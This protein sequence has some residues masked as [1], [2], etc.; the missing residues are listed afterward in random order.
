MQIPPVVLE[1]S[2][3]KNKKFW[4]SKFVFNRIFIDSMLHIF[5]KVDIKPEGDYAK[6]R[7]ENLQT[8]NQG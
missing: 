3:E 5:Q 2:L 7:S 8:Y 6:A 4:L 1:N